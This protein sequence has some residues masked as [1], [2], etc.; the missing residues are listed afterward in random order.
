MMSPNL[1]ELLSSGLNADFISNNS[2]K[3][4]ESES[5]VSKAV[6]V[7]FPIILN[8]ISKNHDDQSVV[9]SILSE[10]ASADEADS[11][12]ISSF[13]AGFLRER[14]IS[15]ENSVANYA[16]I[17][18][19]SSKILFNEVAE[20]VL[21]HL[22]EAA[23]NNNLNATELAT[24][25]SDLNATSQKLLP[26]GV[27]FHALGLESEKE[28]LPEEKMGSVTSKN[29]EENPKI[30]I[31]RQGETHLE[32][33]KKPT[34]G[35]VLKWLFPLLLLLVAAWFIWQQYNQ[36]SAKSAAKMD[37]SLN[38]KKDTAAAREKAVN[39]LPKT[40]STNAILKKRDSLP[41]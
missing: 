3:T 40:D 8:L 21:F 29:V 5:S 15:V 4:G 27:T 7:L 18:E 36:S 2:I 28:I 14:L 22:K 34:I 33:E 25:L 35:S 12:K 41:K 9:D 32:I 10:S 16:D 37:D 11:S 24:G 20:N 30:E 6:S 38:I 13:F 1:T 23:V 19:V 31:T 17:S 26:P 39:D